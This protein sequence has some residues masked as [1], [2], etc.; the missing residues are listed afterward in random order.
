[1]TGEEWF[2]YCDLLDPDYSHARLELYYFI[3]EQERIPMWKY[4]LNSG[5]IEDHHNLSEIT[6][7]KPKAGKKQFSPAFWN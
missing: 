6:T 4:L 7:Y 5:R 2:I 3:D 1:M